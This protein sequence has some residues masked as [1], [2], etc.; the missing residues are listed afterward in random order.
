[1]AIA[2]MIRRESVHVLDCT[3]TVIYKIF[4]YI[5][6]SNNYYKKYAD[7]YK[8]LTIRLKNN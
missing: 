1:M 8:H 7:L 4:L 5:T 6:L 3:Q 2:L